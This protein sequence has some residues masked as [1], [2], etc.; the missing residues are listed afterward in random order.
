MVEQLTC[1][2]KV[3]GS[4]PFSGTIFGQ[5]AQSVEQRI[6]NPCVGSSI[7]PQATILYFSKIYKT[8]NTQIIINNI[9]ESECQKLKLLL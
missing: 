7:L 6:E 2:Q 9:A 3:E 5:V 4:I 1:N 8:P